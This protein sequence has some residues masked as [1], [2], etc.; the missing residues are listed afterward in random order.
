[1]GAFGYFPTRDDD[2]RVL[3]E[4]ARVL[5]PGGVFVIEAVNQAAFVRLLQPRSWSE[6]DNG[7]LF[8]EQRDYDL[9]Q[10]RAHVRWLFVAQRDAA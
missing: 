3:A 4:I 2:E 5:M 9:A 10:G 6:L 8:C 7:T 1:M